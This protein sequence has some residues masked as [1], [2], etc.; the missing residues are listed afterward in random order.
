MKLD[1]VVFVEP[2]TEEKAFPEQKPATKF[3]A[4]CFQRPGFTV[5]HGPAPAEATE[6]AFPDIPFVSDTK[7]G[8]TGITLAVDGNAEMRTR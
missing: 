1:V 2:V 3:L 6:G 5:M 7:I 8:L 4:I